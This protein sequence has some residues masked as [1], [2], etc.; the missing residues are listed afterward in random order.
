MIG[1]GLLSMQFATC[2]LLDRC[3]L[4]FFMVSIFHSR[5]PPT[6]SKAMGE[7]GLVASDVHERSPF[8]KSAEVDDRPL[9]ARLRDGIAALLIPYL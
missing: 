3:T 7:P 8:C 5:Q 6:I 9:A 2:Q 1:E 4:H